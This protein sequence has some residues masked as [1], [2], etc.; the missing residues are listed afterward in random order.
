MMFLVLA[1]ALLVTV[2][3]QA[4]DPT[5]V[6]L[7]DVLQVHQTSLTRDASGTVAYDFPNK[8]IAIRLDDGTRNVFDLSANTLSRINETDSSC[9]QT[10]TP[11]VYNNYVSQ[12]LL[13]GARLLSPEETYLGLSPAR[14]DIQGWSYDVENVG[15]VTI[16]VTKGSPSV[17]V[18]RRF[19][20]NSAT[21]SDILLLVNAKTTIDDATIFDVPDDCPAD[22]IVG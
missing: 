13:S 20:T 9:G 14:L 1:S 19:D 16:G 3:G 17:P 11:S 2:Y 6:C 5:K 21:P 15:T 18:I 4:A 10:P 22:T 7:P 8:V 12:C